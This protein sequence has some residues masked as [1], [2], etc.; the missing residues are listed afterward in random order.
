MKDDLSDAPTTADSHRALVGRFVISCSIPEERRADV[1]ALR[2]AHLAHV[3]RHRDRIA[4]GGVVGPRNAP[5]EA[6]YYFLDVNSQAEATAFVDADP[7]RP[8]YSIV[9]VRAFGQRLPSP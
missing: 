9:Q 6:L 5:P 2:P 7:Y 1:A 3:A 8:L 4:Y